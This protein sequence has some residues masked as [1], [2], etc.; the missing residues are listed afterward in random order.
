MDGG[1]KV[2]PK[3]AEVVRSSAFGYEVHLFLDERRGKVRMAE[4][5]AGPPP[6]GHYGWVGATLGM[7]CCPK[8]GKV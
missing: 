5:I 3:R 7:S 4:T 8:H 2:F 1:A 6:L